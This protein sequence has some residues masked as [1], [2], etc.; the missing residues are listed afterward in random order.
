MIVA[1]VLAL[2]WSP[3]P[4]VAPRVTPSHVT[5]SLVRLHAEPLAREAL[6]PGTSYIGTVTTLA[7]FSAQILNSVAYD[8][9]DGFYYADEGW[10]FYRIESNG[11]ATLIANLESANCWGSA[12]VWDENT[13]LF[14]LS[15]SSGYS[16]TSVSTT[17]TVALVAG[18]TQ[19]TSDGTGSHAQFQYPSGMVLDPPS[20]IFYVVDNDRMRTVTEAG[21]VTTI[22]PTGQLNPNSFGQSY[23]AAL[24]TASGIIGITD[25]P[26]DDVVAFSTTAKTYQVMAGRCI[27]GGFQVPCAPLFVDGP[28]TSALFANPQGIVYDPVSDAFYLVDQANY[29]VRR[30][31]SSG[32]VGRIAG[33]GNPA[34]VD[35]TY[36]AASFD[37]PSCASYDPSTSS[38]IV[39]DNGSARFVTTTGQTPP[40]PR[41]SFMMRTLPTLMSGPSGMATTVDGSIWFAEQTAGMIGRIAMPTRRLHEY[42]LPA[43][44]GHPYHA[45][46]APD[47]NVTFADESGF[48]QFGSPSVGNI[49]EIA[50]N[51][52]V[53]E[54]ALPDQEF[55]WLFA[56]D[57]STGNLWFTVTNF[58]AAIGYM[59]PQHTITQYIMTPA[60]G[61]AV[62]LGSVWVGTSFVFLDR[63]ST[64]GALLAT[65]DVASDEG[66]SIGPDG[67]IWTLSGLQTISRL[68]PVSGKVVVYQL[69]NCNCSRT[70][71]NPVWG[72]DKALWFTEGSC[73]S[74][75]L[76][77]LG[78]LTLHGNY[79]E[80][81]LYEPRSQPQGIA[82]DA[83]GKPW[84]AD[85]GANKIGR[86]I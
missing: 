48:S 69:P 82:F 7:N 58:P 85:L 40:Q 51:G 23:A 17:G 27:P 29:M 60:G 43:G 3:Q 12:M 54:T 36:L 28:A 72:P 49:A 47:G 84:V 35:G 22:G 41:H 66:V 13:H 4:V 14:Y 52:H 15:C 68:N 11:Q 75:T 56:T 74:P 77:A 63:Y 31:S 34:L 2:G 5:E 73:C 62:G 20:H 39:C 38:M 57:Q 53:T 9:D 44:H 42:G 18:G 61:L 24:D 46:L 64:T 59:T 78:R 37:N 83:S 65:Y 79:F 33:S 10:S 71:G 16:I 32:V 26:G 19:G 86:M 55:P 30:L 70:L 1:L 6:R 21:K 80:Y 50:S 67:N 81:P 45:T 25:I 76:G 8:P